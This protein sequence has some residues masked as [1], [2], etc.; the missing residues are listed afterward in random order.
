MRQRFN[1]I[2]YMRCLHRRTIRYRFDALK[3]IWHELRNNCIAISVVLK[4]PTL[5]ISSSPLFFFALFVVYMQFLIIYNKHT[6][7]PL[8]MNGVTRKIAESTHDAK[9]CC[10]ES[11]HT[12]QHCIYANDFLLLFFAIWCQCFVSCFFVCGIF[13]SWVHMEKIVDICKDTISY[14]NIYIRAHTSPILWTFVPVALSSC[15]HDMITKYED[16]NV[17]S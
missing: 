13:A 16:N 17:D 8:E 6:F 15:V 11:A 10:C 12:T 14:I 7:V 4:H 5:H 9:M 1:I 2:I 3:T